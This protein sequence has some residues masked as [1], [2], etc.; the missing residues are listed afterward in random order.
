MPFR[1]RLFAFLLAPLLFSGADVAAKTRAE[2]LR[3]HQPELGQPGKDAVWVPTPDDA[4]SKMLTLARVTSKDYVIDLG[5]GD[6]KIV[7]AAA[8]DFGANALGIEY[9][10]KLVKL[11]RCYVDAERLGNKAKIIEGDVFKEDFSKATVLTI[12]LL[13]EMNLRLRPTILSM[14]PGTRVTTY[15]SRFGDWEP[16]EEAAT[17]DAAKRAYLWIVPAK[18]QGNWEFRETDTGRTKFTVALDQKFQRIAG[19]ATFGAATGP[20]ASAS[21]RGEE[22]RFSFKDDKGQLQ[23]VK[24]TVRGDEISATLRGLG[25]ADTKLVGRRI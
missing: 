1:Q 20:L 2:C 5:A 17:S 3:V 8:K 9:E 7:I 13:P 16:D 4:V 11:A 15:W 12:F 24:G 21:L 19:E 23:D 18:V 25:R 6:G 22:I 14:R 10:P